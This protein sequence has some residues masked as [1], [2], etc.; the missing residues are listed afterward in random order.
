MNIHY[1]KPSAKLEEII[2]AAN[3]ANAHAFIINLSEGYD[4]RVEE[5]GDNLS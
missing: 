4:T 3:I 1:S 5:N 2:E